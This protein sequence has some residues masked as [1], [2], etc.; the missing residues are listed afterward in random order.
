MG[1]VAVILWGA[2]CMFLAPASQRQ[3][4]GMKGNERAGLLY[5]LALLG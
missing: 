5:S 4:R 3:S 1:V 2:L